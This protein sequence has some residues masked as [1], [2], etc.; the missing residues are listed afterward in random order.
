MLA[1]VPTSFTHAG[2]SSAARSRLMRELRLTV[3]LASFTTL[4]WELAHLWRDGPATHATWLEDTLGTWCWDLLVWGAM[5]FCVSRLH[6]K[7]PARGP[8]RWAGLLLLALLSGGLGL[9]AFAE[10]SHLRMNGW[11][12]PLAYLP[13]M[14]MNNTSWGL[15]LVAMEE[16]LDRSRRADAALDAAELQQ[17]ALQGE[18]DQA[19]TQLLQAQ[20]EPHFLFNA[21]ANVR[22]LLRTEPGAARSLLADLGR[23]L[24][25]ALPRLRESETTLAREAE[26]VR[27]FGAIHQ[28][29]MGARLQ[30]QIDIPPA[31]AECRLPPMLLLTLV[32][33]ALKHGLAPLPEGGSI[34]LSARA[35]A[36]GSLLL[37]VADT[38]AGMGS[39]SG[40]GLGLANTRARLKAAYGSSASLALRLNEPRG[41]VAEIRVPARAPPG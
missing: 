35:E 8:R 33:N 40:N 26:L 2:A 7:V 34:T 31:L 17:L 12:M 32:E 16:F 24:E 36:G 11:R 21:L 6:P 18:V 27:A 10:F 38:G 23:Y 37:T 15:L 41:V 25:E 22:R 29:R 3:L 9:A 28:V 13:Y 30:M 5:V 19:R 1:T 39:G 20:I 4:H 14:A